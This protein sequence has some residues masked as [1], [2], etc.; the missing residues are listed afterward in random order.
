MST[1]HSLVRLSPLAR[2]SPLAR[3]AVVIA[4]V[5]A[6]PLVAVS[7]G[8]SDDASTSGATSTTQGTAPA[9]NPGQAVERFND[10]TAP[11][12]VPVGQ[13]FQITLQADAGECFSWDFTTGDTGVVTLVT[14]RPSAIATQDDPPLTG[15]SDLDVF[16]FAADTAGTV[17]LAFKEVSPCEPGTTRDTRSFTVVVTPG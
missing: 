1:N 15:A 10:P 7:C 17:D 3:V 9:Q 8:S 11:I 4:A 12:E 16:E 6:M 14:S 13:V 5:V 2:M